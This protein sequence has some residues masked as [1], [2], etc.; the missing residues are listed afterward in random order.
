MP[1][2]ISSGVCLFDI[3]S[4]SGCERFSNDINNDNNDN[5]IC[6][7]QCIMSINMLF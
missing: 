1:V 5:E 4:T 3:F 7:L 6:T 2:Y